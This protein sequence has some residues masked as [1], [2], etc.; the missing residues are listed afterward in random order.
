MDAQR[1]IDA[2]GFTLVELM[3]AAVIFVLAF[4]VI[5]LSYIRC[6]ELSEMSRN[7]STAL[8]AA[9][10]RIE[11]IK[12]TAFS[13]IFVAYNNAAFDVTGVNGKGVSYVDNTNANLLKVTVTVCWKQKRG[14]IVGEDLDLD[15]QLDGGEDQNGNSLLDSPV[16]LVTYVYNK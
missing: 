6:M 4:V 8:A 5:L 9:K 13:D 11:Q 12:D 16:Q 10:T 14:L 15:G 2:R 3:V 1:K 7:S